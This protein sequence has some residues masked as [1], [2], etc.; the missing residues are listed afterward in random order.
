MTPGAV[1]R[2]DRHV[3]TSAKPQPRRARPADGEA[4]VATVVSA[5]I[6]DP[7]WDYIT[8]ADPNLTHLFA[9]TLFDARVEACQ[10]WMHDD[11]AA[12]ALWDAPRGHEDGEAADP[13]RWEAYRRAA[14]AAG[15]ARLTAYDDAVA[16]ARPTEP[17]WYLGVLATRP[18]ARGQGLA[19]TVLEPVFAQADAAGLPCCLE[20]SKTGNLDFYRHRGFSESTAVAMTEGPATWWLTRPAR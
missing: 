20:T 14:G 3:T 13:D 18:E 1:V 10:V 17:Y 15:W 9:A 4:V 19:T 7:A 11:A 5:F 8:G 2:H 12:V 16:A 6:G